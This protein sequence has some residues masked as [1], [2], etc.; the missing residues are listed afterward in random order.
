MHM[1]VVLVVLPWMLLLTMQAQHP[2][3][4]LV[5]LHHL[6]VLLLVCWTASVCWRTP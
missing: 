2:Q 5:L 1:G 4:V 3:E 6:V